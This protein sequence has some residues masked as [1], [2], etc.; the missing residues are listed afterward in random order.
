MASK[1]VF[2]LHSFSRLEQSYRRL[3]QTNLRQ[4]ECFFCLLLGD[5]FT[6][7]WDMKCR[8]PIGQFEQFGQILFG[9]L[10]SHWSR[11]FCCDFG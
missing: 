9:T 1:N 4:D 10:Q 5:S 3:D 11:H 6:M 2:T 7:T 8:Y